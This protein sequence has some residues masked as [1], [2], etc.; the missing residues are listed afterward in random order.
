MADSAPAGLVLRGRRD[1]CAVIDRLLHGAVDGRSGVLLVR[2]EAGVGK[3]A[4]LE[5]A[6]GWASDLTGLRAVGGGAEMELPFAALHQLC[7]PM[8][9]R[10]ERLPS[11]QRDA[12]RTTFGLSAGAAPDRFLVGLATL[13]LLAEVAEERALLCVVDDGQ[14][15]DHASVQALAF[16]ARRLLAEHVVMLFAA[17]EPSGELTGLP[18]LVVEGVRDA[19]ARAILGSV[20]PGRLDERVTDQLVAEAGGNP[21]ALLELPR[22]LSAARLAGGVGL[23]G[24]VSLSGGVEGSFL[25]RVVGLPGDT[26]R[27][28]RFG[29]AGPAGGPALPWGAGRPRAEDTR[30]LLLLAAAEPTGDP[31]LLWRAAERLGI[32]GPVLEPAESAGLIEIDGRVRFRH[33]L[34]RSAVYRAATPQE[35]RQVHRALADA[36]DAQVDPDRRAWHVAEAATG[37][38]EGVAVDLESAADRAQARGGLA[39]AAAFFE[40]AAA[41]TRDQTRRGDRALAAAQTKYE[42]GAFDDALALLATVDAAGAHGARVNLLR[43]QIAFVVQRGGDAPG[44][45]LE[46]ARELEAFDPDRARTTYL[47]AIEAA[48]FAGWLARGADIVEVSKAALAGPAPRRSAR[49]TDLLLQG[50]AT[51]P[52]DGHAAAVPILKAALSAFREE[53]VLPPEEE[54]WLSL[55]CRAAWDICDEESWRLLATRALQHARDAGALTVTPLLLSSLSYVHVLCG[56]LSEAESLLAEIRATTAVTGIPAHRYVEI[57]VAALRGREPEL[58]ALVDD[59]V[60]DAEERGEGFALAFAGQARA[61]LHNGLGRYEEALTAVREAV[62]VAP[63]SELSTPSA[64]AELVEAAARVGEHRI[65]ARALERL[66]LTTGPSGTDWALGVEARS[67]ALLSDGDVAERLY[68]DAI[69][70]LRRTRVRLQLARTH[71]LYGEWLRRERRRPDAREHLR[72]ALEL[73]T[74]MGAEA[75]AARAERELLATGERVRKRRIETAEQLT[76]QEIQVVRLA[77]DGLSNSAIGERLFISQHTV[78]YHLRKVFTKL[79]VTSRNQLGPVLPQSSEPA[80][81][82]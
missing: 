29:A 8:L 47:E 10:L 33:P 74:S 75:F 5:Y 40:R 15:L 72:A 58:S 66:T 55:A 37:T 59:F 32:T 12:L 19:D 51:L 3:T 65:A 49:P 80:G 60:T 17:R 31:A 64:V 68:Q 35:R 30:R 54:R 1:E 38:D 34:V 18:E 2:G 73:F 50:M 53:A 42:A 48:R 39:A 28:L 4:L 69:E 81:L 24:A 27:A 22:E 82:A 67:R 26:P 21:L 9:D 79:D 46:A 76:V 6:I 44:L 25:P 20:I 52:I 13:S 7:A 41:L 57:W 43:A 45:L 61:V 23:P 78:A 63:Y 77:R 16:A 71:L 11:P 36:T 56:E 14:W 62:D 70:R